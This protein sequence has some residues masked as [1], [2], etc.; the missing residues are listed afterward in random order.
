VPAPL[1]SPY[2]EPALPDTA[3]IDQIA[4]RAERFEKYIE[5]VKA[6]IH[7]GFE[8]YAYNTLANF[9]IFKRLLHGEN[10]RLLRLI[11]GRPVLDIGCA[12]GDGA[13]FLESLGCTVHAVDHPAPN[14][15]GMEGVRTLKEKL[16]SRIE[17][18]EV[19]L[20][21][22]F[23]LP[24]ADCGLAMLLGVPYHLKNPF[25]VL[26]RLSKSAQ[27]LLVSTRIA[28]MFPPLKELVDQIPAAYLLDRGELNADATN[29]WIFSAAGFRRLLE[30]TNWRPLDELT[31]RQVKRSDPT[32]LDRDERAFYLA[33]SAY[34]LANVELERGWHAPEGSGWRWTEKAFSVSAIL[35]GEPRV[36]SFS[37]AF[38]IP[39]VALDGGYTLTLSA[40]ADGAPFVPETYHQPGEYAY[41]RFI[42]ARC[43]KSGKV[44]LDFTLDRAL[45]PD[46]NDARERGLVVSSFSID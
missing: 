40:M 8:W 33:Q 17:I 43:W 31:P 14:M 16:G 3:D 1:P 34:A 6:T 22:Q 35:A 42:P 39:P 28:R 38:Y 36:A 37:L 2:R 25:Y 13:F 15:N 27:H 20:D 41:T 44:R 24:V 4:A 18:H 7:P 11:A 29:Y 45:A 26:E 12:D 46:A 32:S 23:Q 10:R 5:G 21:S 19:D 30:R 9:S